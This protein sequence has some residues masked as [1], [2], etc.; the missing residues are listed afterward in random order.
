M[1]PLLQVD[2][3]QIRYPR[4][5]WTS[6]WVEVV[7]GVS[8]E[9]RRGETLAIVGESGSGKTSLAMAL[10]GLASAH[11]GR[12]LYNGEE[13]LRDARERLQ[14]DRRRV[15]LMFQDATGSLSPRMNVRSQLLEPFEI[16]SM[17][18]GDRDQRVN[19]LL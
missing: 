12:V 8:F 5:G 11:K 18:K 6:S 9:I 4:G 14:P 19:R 2:G 17:D 13:V 3:L 7:M 15:V 16:H 10:M 1:T